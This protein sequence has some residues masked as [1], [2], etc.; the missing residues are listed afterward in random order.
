MKRY[1]EKILRIIE[2]R[3]LVPKLASILLAVILWAYISSAKSGEVKFKLPVTFAGLEEDY[4]VSKAS[5]KY[6]VVEIT[7]N[8][9][10]LKNISSKNIKLQVDLTSVEPGEYKPY[11]IQYQKI[12]FTDD[13]KVE[14]YPEEVKI[15]VEKKVAR[16]IRIIPRFSGYTVKGFMTGRIRVNPEYVKVS[17]PGSVV[18]NIG[19]L[20]TD[21]IPV[22]GKNAAFRQ[23]IKIEKV[24]EEELEYNIS[25][26]NVIV[27]VINFSEMTTLEIPLVIRNKK[28]GY[29]YLFN[30]DKVKINVILPENKNINEESFSAYIDAGEI[31]IDNNEFVKK[32]KIEIMGFVH[33]N[34]DSSETDNMII[35]T[36]PDSIEIVVTKE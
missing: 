35:S 33:V 30:P 17:G 24:N 13:F 25:K 20:Y 9:D 12:D 11:K 14:L 2:N 5:H 29:N 22:D 36:T 10:D 4:I 21:E 18:N 28:A 27:P 19:A 6:V 31:E 8:K 26:V 7:G 16:N 34:G 15:L 23:D 3:N 32:S 1:I